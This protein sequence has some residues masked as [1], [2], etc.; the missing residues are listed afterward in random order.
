MKKNVLPAVA[1]QLAQI[2]EAAQRD[3]ALQKARW[4]HA[5]AAGNFA[6]AEAASAAIADLKIRLETST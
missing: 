3:L 5:V 4:K 2:S 6:A 1:A